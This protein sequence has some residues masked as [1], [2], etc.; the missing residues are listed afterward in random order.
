[1]SLKP[2]HRRK[3]WKHSPQQRRLM[4]EEIAYLLAEGPLV[5]SAEA[6]RFAWELWRKS[7]GAS[8]SWPTHDQY[9]QLFEASRWTVQRWVQELEGANMVTFHRPHNGTK[10]SVYKLHPPSKWR[11]RDG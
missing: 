11:Y 7:Y 1:M 6:R 2:G 4:T 8:S 9:G 3:W 5:I 10:S